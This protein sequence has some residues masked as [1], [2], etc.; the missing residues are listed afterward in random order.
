MGNTYHGSKDVK[1]S[2]VEW[3]RGEDHVAIADYQ[4]SYAWSESHVTAFV[5]T[6][7]D[8]LADQERGAGTHAPDIGVVVIEKTQSDEASSDTPSSDTSKEVR[9]HVVDGQQRLLTF[10]LLVVAL[11]GDAV[12]GP[13]NVDRSQSTR[14]QQLLHPQNL[15]SV[16]PRAVFS[17][18]PQGDYTSS[19]STT[20]QWSL[21][22]TSLQISAFRT[23]SFSRSETR[24]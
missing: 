16:I 12:C 22:R 9:F 4:R 18:P 5:E 19:S 24:K 8:A 17:S 14:L 13:E 10:S 2:V 7:L 3:L 21:P 23:L 11:C 6:L 20:G 1:C 15:E